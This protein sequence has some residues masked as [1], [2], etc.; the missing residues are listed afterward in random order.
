[1]TNQAI[2]EELGQI[3]NQMRSDDNLYPDETQL[4]GSRV[5]EL[6]RRFNYAQ[7]SSDEIAQ[8]PCLRP[9]VMLNNLLQL[10]VLLAFGNSTEIAQLLAPLAVGRVLIK[11][12]E[13]YI[14]TLT[15]TQ[16][17]TI[18]V[19]LSN[20]FEIVCNG[21]SMNDC[22]GEVIRLWKKAKAYDLML[23]SI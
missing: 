19:L 3:V 15:D 13:P 22:Y 14:G 8:D 10:E 12:G 16:Y 6:V 1:M 4:N 9:E 5:A 21:V 17:D 7:Y 23:G 11:T 2:K 20:N 18:E